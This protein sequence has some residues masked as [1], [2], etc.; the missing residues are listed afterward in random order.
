MV[1]GVCWKNLENFLPPRALSDAESRLGKESGSST[2]TSVSIQGRFSIRHTQPPLVRHFPMTNDSI[3]PELEAIMARYLHAKEAG[4]N[5]K[6]EDWVAQYPDFAKELR[7]FVDNMQH[8]AQGLKP[9]KRSIDSLAAT[10]QF[11]LTEPEHPA[12]QATLFTNLRYF[13]DYELLHEIAR[14]GM[15]I[16]FRAKQI[17]LNRCVAV[18]MILAGRLASP[19]SEARFCLEAQAAA[20][21]DHP[22]IVPIYEIGEHEGQRYFS[23]KLIEGSSLALVGKSRGGKEISIEQSVGIMAIVARAVHHAHQ[24][25]ILHRDIK[26][27]NILLDAQQMPHVTDFGLA[28]RFEGEIDLTQ[29]NALVGTPSYMSP[30]QARGERNLT[31]AADVFSIAAV[32]F[33]LVYGHPPHVAPTAA[34][35]LAKILSSDSIRFPTRPAPLDADLETILWKSLQYQPEKRY[36]SAAALAEDLENWLEGKPI[37][38]RRSTLRERVVKWARR[39][40]AVA[41]LSLTLLLSSCVSIAT[42]VREWRLAVDAKNE[43]IRAAERA[44]AAEAN[45]HQL[46][47]HSEELRKDLELERDLVDR[48]RYLAQMQLAGHEWRSGA[49][50][51][52]ETLLDA[53]ES[54]SSTIDPRSWEWFFLRGQLRGAVIAT[55]IHHAVTKLA[56]DASGERIAASC[57]SPNASAGML[58]LVDAQTGKLEPVLEAD[59]PHWL[60]D[61]AWSPDGE[62]LAFGG[63]GT[64]GFHNKSPGYLAV[65]EAGQRESPLPLPGQMGQVQALSWKPDST[66]FVAASGNFGSPGQVKIWDVQSAEMTRELVGHLHQ[67]VAVDWSPNQKWIAGSTSNG[68]ILIWD[69]ESGELLRRWT[70]DPQAIRQLQWNSSSTLLVMGNPSHGIKV[71]D[72][73]DGSLIREISSPR[74][75][76]IQMEWLAE[77]TVVITYNDGRSVLLDVD[78]GKMIERK[79]SGGHL[80]ACAASSPDRK[81][82]AF[83]QENSVLAIESLFP[84]PAKQQLVNWDDRMSSLV[85]SSDGKSIATTGANVSLWNASTRKR[86]TVLPWPEGWTVL[87]AEFSPDGGR[88]AT[89]SLKSFSGTIHIMDIA[90]QKPLHTW[91]GHTGIVLSLAWSLDGKRLVTAGT[92]GVVR[93][94]NASANDDMLAE[95]SAGKVGINAMS[96]HP[97]QDVVA[98]GGSNGEVLLLTMPDVEKGAWVVRRKSKAHS[99]EI[100]DLCWNHD[101]SLLATCSSDGVKCLSGETLEVIQSI[102]NQLGFV[103][104]LAFRPP[105]D[106]EPARLAA[107][108]H[109]KGVVLWDVESGREAISLPAPNGVAFGWSPDGERLIIANRDG[110]SDIWDAGMGRSDAR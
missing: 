32:L 8:V 46:L 61:V 108:L 70:A 4:E 57:Y 47:L 51:N 100:R 69:A 5:T 92:D 14:G 96:K 74:E 44:L 98:V 10:N 52:L 56:W 12:A 93:L 1:R 81:R 37:S 77:R 82:I 49:R 13:G 41:A 38:A 48:T 76:S 71:W 59:F 89:S 54:S 7:A 39:K 19:E 88:L 18:K 75:I 55:G 45:E 87:A 110:E 11:G 80:G 28:K 29:S 73:R 27:A 20:S 22:H 3:S 78:S 62:W 102:S 101:G 67:P 83:F 2:G 33:E 107:L 30:E 106:Q 16:V 24:R 97:M 79:K 58:Y 15:G 34:A 66:H 94:W 35:T 95:W 86:E 105:H 68:E 65:M 42:I 26:P 103:S 53:Q 99:G 23:M 63:G 25:G 17:S 64:A 9:M 85:W 6:I 31:V 21:L 91:L 104:A 50:S 109:K 40:P 90:T 72:S 43:S 60:M 36:A 84:E